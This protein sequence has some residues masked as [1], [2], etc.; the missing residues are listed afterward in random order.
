MF[1]IF[2]QGVKLLGGEFLRSSGNAGEP[3]RVVSPTV[4]GRHETL[5]AGDRRETPRDLNREVLTLLKTVPASV[6]R[7]VLVPIPP[8]VLK[9]CSQTDAGNVT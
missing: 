5:T 2:R 3:R 9:L 7:L 1:L 4:S 8:K 6:P